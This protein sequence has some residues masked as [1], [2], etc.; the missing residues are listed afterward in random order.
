MKRSL[1]KRLFRNAGA[2]SFGVAVTR[3]GYFLALPLVWNNLSTEDLGVLSLAQIIGVFVVPILTLNLSASGQRIF[4]EWSEDVRE[5]NYWTLWLLSA[6]FGLMVVCALE[7]IGQKLLGIL[8]E[9]I[10]YRPYC[11]IVVWTQ[12]FV[13]L[14]QFPLNRYRLLERLKVYNICTIG[15]FLTLITFVLMALFFWDAGL[16]GYLL[17]LMFNAALWLVIH[18]ILAYRRCKPR[19]R[20]ECI[21]PSLAYSLPTIPSEILDTC[22]SVFDRYFLD[23]HVSLGKI[24]IYGVAHQ[25]ATVLS[26]VNAALKASFVPLVF[27]EA[28]ERDDLHQELGKLG[29]KYVSVFSIFAL[30]VAVFGGDVLVQLAPERLHASAEL[31]PVFV[32]GM[33][34]MG[35]STGM[36]RGI[37][38]A[39]KNHLSIVVSILSVCISIGSLFYLVPRYG[40]VGAAAGFSLTIGVRTSLQIFFAMN[41]Y[42]R[43]AEWPR[44][45]A[46]VAVNLLTYFASRWIVSDGFLIRMLL[47]GVL[48]SG[49]LALVV[50]VSFGWRNIWKFIGYRFRVV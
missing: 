42:P 39:K 43:V 29:L 27:R 36:G 33:F 24:G 44:F 14:T 31:I 7:L 4:F 34:L 40:I 17:A 28:S 46:I 35:V 3:F 32:L 48:F 12:L 49:S 5:E 20:L 10:E 45:G 15:A 25:V 9:K 2:Y 6:L 41:L 38:L 1:S 11:R 21:R 26:S 16:K 22:G 19:L 37:D 47:K 30:G 50:S 13:G 18:F 8:I 23:K